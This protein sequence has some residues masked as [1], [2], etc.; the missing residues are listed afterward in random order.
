MR[1][2]HSAKA[3]ILLQKAIDLDRSDHRIIHRLGEYCM[4]TEDYAEARKQLSL[5][6]IF[7]SAFGILEFHV[8]EYDIHQIPEYQSCIN[9]YTLNTLLKIGRK[10]LKCS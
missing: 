4:G 1:F 2:N 9:I 3:K 6:Y 10:K 5:L 7:Q 8:G